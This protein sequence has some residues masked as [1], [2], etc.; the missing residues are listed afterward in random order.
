MRNRLRRSS[1]FILTLLIGLSGLTLVVLPRLLNPQGSEEV[2]VGDVVAEDIRAPRAIEVVD[3]DTTA[4]ARTQAQTEQ[5]SVFDAD[6]QLE[7]GIN[8]DLHETL[9]QIAPLP[10]D[11]ARSELLRRL[12][13]QLENDEV[14]TV[15][16]HAEEMQKRVSE[17]LHTALTGYVVASR[18]VLAPDEERGII[19]RRLG[20]V[21]GREDM[22]DLSQVIDLSAARQQMLNYLRGQPLHRNERRVILQVAEAL[23]R[24]SLVFNR[25]E[26][27]R[28]KLQAAA[29]VKPVLVALAQGERIAKRGDHLSARQ[30]L[31]LRGIEAQAQ[32]TKSTQRALGTSLLL[33]TMALA[34]LRFSRGLSRRPLR[35]RDGV[36]AISVLIAQMLM[37]RAHHYALSFWDPALTVPYDALLWAA[38]FATGALVVR[39]FLAEQVG[40]VVGLVSAVAASLM[41]DGSLSL[42]LYVLAG[43]LI[44]ATSSRR[45]LHLLRVG[46]EIG[47]AQAAIA[48]C[49]VVLEAAPRPLELLWMVGAAFASALASA[50]I[51]ALVTPVI[52]AIFGFTTE[53]SLR[54]LATLNHPLHKQLIVAA[55]GTYHHSVVMGQMVEAAAEAIG[56]D[57]LLAK[58]GAYF[59][60]VGK[61]EHPLVYSENRRA[62][63]SDVGLSESDLERIA[64]H[65]GEG[66]SMIRKARLG[67]AVAAIVRA[68]H[69]T[70][71]VGR[72]PHS[73]VHGDEL[74]ES[75][76]A[77]LVMIADCVET[78]VRDARVAKP[79]DIERIVDDI[80]LDLF[81][82][83]Q[84][85]NCE[86]PLS[87]LPL[88]KDAFVRTLLKVRQAK[89]GMQLL[90]VVG[91]NEK[92][93]TREA[94]NTDR[95]HR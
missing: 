32:K 28:R 54:E 29:E 55:P 12:D 69:G 45:P 84:L 16:Q 75:K 50:L 15:Q 8:A 36:F 40:L 94:K 87:A 38:P 83:G 37:V 9:T 25:D 33:A 14:A 13:V 41:F 20:Q 58:V 82:D 93:I 76:E 7:A 90:V 3:E 59:H 56:A 62:G 77:A 10:L 80:F 44:A 46:L 64:R 79:M 31:I 60:D 72:D 49:A 61:L 67:P 74:P 66:A 89:D 35:L 26:T 70:R 57:T 39:L 30:V 48:I 6:T 91:D 71:H 22:S 63:E 78:A 86:L 43:S 65:S 23:L 53:L 34:S 17:C 68:H 5:R 51:C 52:E 73:P 92:K 27:E 88:I 95:D 47:L 1:P 19:I 24:P 18:D 81:R 21:P 4:L 2:K 11:V 42:L 85:A